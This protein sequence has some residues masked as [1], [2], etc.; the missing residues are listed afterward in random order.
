ME[1]VHCNT[2]CTVSCIWR[3]NPDK[4][5]Q[6]AKLLAIEEDSDKYFFYSLIVGFK[7]GVVSK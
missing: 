7:E 5:R 4:F 3:A 1:I 6:P 2:R